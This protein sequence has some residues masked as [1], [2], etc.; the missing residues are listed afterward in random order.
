MKQQKMNFGTKKSYSGGKNIVDDEIMEKFLSINEQNCNPTIGKYSSKKETFYE[1]I[2]KWQEER[3]NK[4]NII[5]PIQFTFEITNRC[6]CNCKDC[7]M[8]ANSIKVG[9]TK[10]NE[11]E[12][13]KLVDDL[14]E[15]GVT[16]FA[17]TGGEPFL[18]FENMCK[19]L[20]Y[21]ENK[22]D[23]SKIISN[24]FWGKNV[25]YYFKKLEESGLLKNQ[26]FVP[27]LQI[28]IGEQTIPLEDICNI[29]YYVNTHY[30]IEQLN[31]GIIH[32]RLN[33]EGESQLSKLYN[34]YIKKYGEFPN[35]RIYLTDSYYVNANSEAKEEI[36]TYKMSVYNAINECDNRFNVEVGKFVSPKIFMKCNGDCYPCEVFNMHK[37]LFLGNYFEIGLAKV[38]E[39]LNNNKYVRFIRKYG[40]VGFREVIPTKILKQNF[41]E[42]SCY[43]CEFCIKLCE[44]NNLIR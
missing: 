32:T 13:Y 27:S 18:E 29:I 11:N 35:G 19:M 2:K 1:D 20:K 15:Q 3:T 21:S 24:G 14:Y 37:D 9:K 5:K 8:S 38:L 36:E 34:S 16:A 44:K 4:N 25:E 22:L 28:S 41:C 7:G 6:N 12:I 26:F 17:I 39:N 40:T 10:L 42:T 30:T 23:V 33:N 43:G 31:F